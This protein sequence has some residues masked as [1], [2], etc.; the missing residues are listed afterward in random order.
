MDIK[1]ADPGLTFDERSRSPLASTYAFV[2]SR[3]WT[4]KA[5]SV[6]LAMVLVMVCF[7]Q[8]VAPYDPAA[9]DL[10]NRLQAPSAEHWLGTDHLGRDVL[11]RLLV[12]GQFAVTISA[13]TVIITLVV[14]TLIGVV[15]G[16]AGGLVDEVAM[17]VVDLL[18]AIPDVVIAIFLIGVFGPNYVT[19]ILSLTLIGW[20]PYA[21]LARGLA[22]EVNAREYIR[23]A[24]VLGM[25]RSFV[26]LRHIVPNTI[27]P[28]AAVSFLR[29]GHKLIT[30]GGL[31]Y[32]GLGVRPPNPDWGLMMAE[33][34]PYLERAPILMIA[35]GAVIFLAALGVTWI[36]HGLEI[37]SRGARSRAGTNAEEAENGCP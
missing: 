1:M 35:P 19:L 10:I 24:E 12:G 32:L 20:T 21:R 31:S 15:A 14:G 22:K 27:R 36:G 5:G 25:K 9:Q 17:R 11:S 16:R 26:I 23:A 33:A 37:E 30:V 8:W 2:S 29:F 3:H 4:F 28:V 6:L 18:I 13:I 7:A 34:Q